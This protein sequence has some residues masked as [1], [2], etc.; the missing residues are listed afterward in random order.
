MKKEWHLK[1]QEAIQKAEESY[2]MKLRDCLSC[3]NPSEMIFYLRTILGL[4]CSECGGSVTF[5]NLS[6]CNFLPSVKC[7]KCQHQ[8]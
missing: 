1:N 5:G 3:H 6:F 4:S 8:I 7:Y 2:G